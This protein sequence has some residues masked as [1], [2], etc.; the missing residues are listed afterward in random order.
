MQRLVMCLAF[1]LFG[2]VS[3]NADVAPSQFDG[4]FFRLSTSEQIR[5]FQGYDLEIRY[6][7]L[8]VGNQIV[9]PPAIY[10]VQEFAKQGPSAIPF[11][12]S[13]L[14]QAKEE[15]SIRDI[16]AI[17]AEMH[18]L[19]SYDESINTSMKALVE[20]RVSSMQGQWKPVTQRML[21]EIGGSSLKGKDR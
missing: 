10:L 14:A 1:I 15:A 19:K 21:Q 13:K 2:C 12:Q 16:V 7:L 3:R 5:R 20:N 4:D 11:L 9:H 6:E 8:V 17:L 18:R